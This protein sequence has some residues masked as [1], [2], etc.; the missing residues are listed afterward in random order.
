MIASIESV[1]AFLGFCCKLTDACELLDYLERAGN[2]DSLS[3]MACVEELPVLL[4]RGPHAGL[5]LGRTS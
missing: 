1:G 3:E 2:D 4:Q 5:V